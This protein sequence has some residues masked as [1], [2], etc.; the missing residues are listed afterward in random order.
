MHNKPEHG[1]RKDVII[2]SLIHEIDVCNPP[3]E[4]S[5]AYT[6]C[7]A[8]STILLKS[9]INEIKTLYMIFYISSTSK[10]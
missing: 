2:D 7:L 6:V 1:K 10:S 3:V 5:Q 4:N 8:Y 9:L